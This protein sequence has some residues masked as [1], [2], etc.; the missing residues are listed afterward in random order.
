MIHI[1]K[2]IE[3]KTSANKRIN[4]KNYPQVQIRHTLI[5]P[6][7][8]GFNLTEIVIS[9]R[10]GIIRRSDI[11]DLLTS[12]VRNRSGRI[13]INCKDMPEEYLGDWEIE[14]ENEDLYYITKI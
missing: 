13:H 4:G 10:R 14:K 6:K 12:K 5:V 8:V 2:I 1:C 3:E 9:L 7:E 11:D